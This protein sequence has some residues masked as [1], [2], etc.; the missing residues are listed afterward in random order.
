MTEVGEN[1]RYNFFFKVLTGLS[2]RNFS[3]VLVWDMSFQELKALGNVYIYS[4]FLI[5]YLPFILKEKRGHI[6][7]IHLSPKTSH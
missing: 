3:I 1:K 7:G 6:I 2:K 4:V 5:K